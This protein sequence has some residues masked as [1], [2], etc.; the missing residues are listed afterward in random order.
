M[1]QRGNI[2]VG[3]LSCIISCIII[4]IGI[5]NIIDISTNMTLKEKG[6][7]AHKLMLD[8][9]EYEQSV[10]YEEL[11]EHGKRFKLQT[12]IVAYIYGKMFIYLRYEH[13][14]TLNHTQELLEHIGRRVHLLE[15]NSLP[16]KEEQT[17]CLFLTGT[18]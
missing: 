14:M 9:H 1:N 10:I 13:K 6:H 4:V 3:T 16:S 18:D 5:I 8:A 2:I 17:Y 12:F 7:M 11:K 15:M